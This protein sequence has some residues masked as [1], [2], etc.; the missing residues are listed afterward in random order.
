MLVLSM[1]TRFSILVTAVIL[2]SLIQTNIVSAQ[3]VAEVMTKADMATDNVRV[4]VEV[5]DSQWTKGK[6]SIV[7]VKI[8]NI[9]KEIININ[10]I[11]SFIFKKQSSE[12]GNNKEKNEVYWCPI[13][14]KNKSERA[15]N[16]APDMLR[17]DGEQAK[18]VE[19]DVDN[20]HCGLS[21]SALWPFQNFFSIV[22]SGQYSIHLNLYVLNDNVFKKIISQDTLVTIK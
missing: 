21:I 11:P 10:V 5:S 18:I 16:S 19:I 4:S 12:Y 17:L 8:E 6:I 2:V 9:S 22:Q 3:N 7:H 1:M 20:L 14:L 15:K 13:N